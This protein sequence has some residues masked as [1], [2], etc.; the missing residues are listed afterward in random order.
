MV[1]VFVCWSGRDGKGKGKGKI[2]GDLY[3]GWMAV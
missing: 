1:G 2:G 3:E